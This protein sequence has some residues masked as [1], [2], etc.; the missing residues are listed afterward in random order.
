MNE[1][2][3]RRFKLER[4]AGWTKPPGGRSVARPHRWSNPHRVEELGRAEAVRRYESDLL[5][6]RLVDAADIVLDVDEA[7]RDLAGHHLGCF[8]PLTEPC[9]ADVLLHYANQANQ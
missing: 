1:Q 7:R 2:T 4:R 6:G 5:A 8:C 3:P 9:H